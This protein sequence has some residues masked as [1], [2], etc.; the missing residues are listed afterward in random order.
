MKIRVKELSE[1]CKWNEYYGRYDTPKEWTDAH[2]KYR[3]QILNVTEMEED[4]IVLYECFP[5][6]SFEL[7]KIS[8]L[9]IR[10]LP[11]WVEIIEGE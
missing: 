1:W 4:G 11:E 10:F 9:I 2:Y 8:T 5:E 3:G 6:H 7:T